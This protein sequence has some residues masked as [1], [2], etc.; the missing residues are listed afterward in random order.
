M[1]LKAAS[2][3]EVIRAHVLGVLESCNWSQSKTAQALSVDRKTIYRM[4]RRW[5][6]DVPTMRARKA[7][8]R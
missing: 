3:E 6:L 4:L 1:E 7:G 8:E 2:L 5:G